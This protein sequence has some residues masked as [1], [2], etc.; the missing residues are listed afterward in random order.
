MKWHM[1][2]N[3][4]DDDDASSQSVKCVCLQE[5]EIL[6]AQQ[7]GLSLSVSVCCVFDS[8]LAA[9]LLAGHRCLMVHSCIYLCAC[10]HSIYFSPA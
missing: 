9:L 8:C 2:P 7:N 3:V 5:C 10:V 1:H 4:D 6:K